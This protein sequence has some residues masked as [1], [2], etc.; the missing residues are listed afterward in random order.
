M[1]GKKDKKGMEKKREG[2]KDERRDQDQEEKR[3]EKKE[4]APNGNGSVCSVDGRKAHSLQC[5]SSILSTFLRHHSA[6]KIN[7]GKGIYGTSLLI[8]K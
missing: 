5:C 6:R 7:T 3:E 2:E 4:M 8:S 1:R